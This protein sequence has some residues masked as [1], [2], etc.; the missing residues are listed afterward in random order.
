MGTVRQSPV[1]KNEERSKGIFAF[2]STFL[3]FSNYCNLHFLQIE[4]NLPSWIKL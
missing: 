2:L 4:E 3:H 1:Q